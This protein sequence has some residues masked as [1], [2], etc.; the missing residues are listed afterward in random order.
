MRVLVLGGYGFIGEAICRVLHVRGHAVTGLGRDVGRARA[1]MP[2]VRWIEGDIAGLASAEWAALVT[3]FDAVVNAAGALQDGARDDVAA[4]QDAAMRALYN[5]AA[6]QDRPPLIVQISA[7]TAGAGADT[8]FLA[9]KRA[10]DN[11]LKASGLPHVILRPALVIGRNAHGGTALVRALAGFPLVMPLMQT[12]S[13]VVTV[14]LEDVAQCVADAV[15]GVIAPGSDLVLA[16]DERLTL[17]ECVAAHRAWLGLPSGRIVEVPGWAGKLAG[18]AA[19]LAGRLGWRS[20]LRST[21]LAVMGGGVEAGPGSRPERHLL[22]L[23]ET[24]MR[25]P[26][27][28]QD[29]WFARLYLLKPVLVLGLSAFWVAS[30]SIALLGFEASAQYMGFAGLP[31]RLGRGLTLLTSLADIALGAA[32]LW[33]VWAARAL[34]GMMV[35]SLAYLVAATI[36]TPALWLDPLGPLVKVVPSILLA[37]VTLAILDER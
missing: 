3:G 26:A 35:L 5:A 21:A 9:T 24:L 28:A 20:P 34:Q 11:T 27:G 29:L 23:N 16:A 7:N 12:Q 31:E 32:V 8:P 30:G 37:A 25:M 1:R 15:E 18:M 33:R 19:D 6:V 22:P 13:P 4:V 2:F 14:A 10:A 36:L 17:K